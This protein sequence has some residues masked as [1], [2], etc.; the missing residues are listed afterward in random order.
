MLLGLA[1]FRILLITGIS[2]VPRLSR[3]T[4]IAVVEG[5]TLAM[6]SFGIPKIVL[7]TPHRVLWLHPL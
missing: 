2:M 4:Q 3:H 1:L 5:G 6:L 7:T